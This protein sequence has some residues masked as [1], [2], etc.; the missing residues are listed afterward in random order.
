MNQQDLHP[1]H[2]GLL[3]GDLHQGPQN[4]LPV[5]QE[6][7]VSSL[8]GSSFDTVPTLAFDAKI[9]GSETTET[10]AEDFESA[11]VKH[12]GIEQN[13]KPGHKFESCKT[14]CSSQKTSQSPLQAPEIRRPR[15]KIKLSRF[16][17]MTL[18]KK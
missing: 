3:Q 16:G 2:Q 15:Q 13:E 10:G 14:L 12:D 5:T 7:P 4:D 8:I 17:K 9:L 18:Q 1:C 6:L 11:T